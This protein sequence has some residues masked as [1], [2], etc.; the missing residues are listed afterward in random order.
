MYMLSHAHINGF[1]HT[2]TNL[3]S[4]KDGRLRVVSKI[5]DH[6][7]DIKLFTAQHSAYYGAQSIS[8]YSL[9]RS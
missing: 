2:P 3:G 8:W 4:M 6:S 5:K 7:L 9:D 1:S